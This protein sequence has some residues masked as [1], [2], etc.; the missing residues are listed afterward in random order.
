LVLVINVVEDIYAVIKKGRKSRK[1]RGFSSYELKEAGLSFLQALELCI[2]IDPK[3]STKYD[4][5]VDTLNA[6]C[7]VKATPPERDID[8]RE[9]KGIGQKRAEQLKAAG[10]DSVKKLAESKPQHLAE[11]MGVSENRA[12]NWIESAKTLLSS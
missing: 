9:V 1:G 8:L 7:V 4:E 10:F 2:P 5:N 3:R 12:A 6:Y 11:G